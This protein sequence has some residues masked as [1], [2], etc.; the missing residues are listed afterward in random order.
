MLGVFKKA[1]ILKG[2]KMDTKLINIMVCPLCKSSL[3][4]DKGKQVL[5]CKADKLAYS[6][7][8][9][10]LNQLLILIFNRPFIRSPITI[11]FL[12]KSTSSINTLSL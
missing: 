7:V 10:I 4:Y 12:K 8:D 2:I 11:K 1:F 6:I 3:I 5:I 9:G